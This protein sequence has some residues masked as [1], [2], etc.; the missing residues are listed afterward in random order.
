MFWL[1]FVDPDK[2]KGEQFLGAIAVQGDDMAAAVAR[3]RALGIN[4]GG[5]VMGVQ[6]NDESH[7][8]D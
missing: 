2:P 8:S 4:P 3:T 7:H 1:S 5:E 6:F